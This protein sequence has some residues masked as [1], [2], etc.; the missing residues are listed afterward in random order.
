MSAPQQTLP[1][2]LPQK[3]VEDIVYGIDCTAQLTGAQTP[4]AVSVTLTKNGVPVTLVDPPIVVGNV[5]MQRVRTMVLAVGCLYQM[6]ALFT[7]ST[8]TN[9]LALDLGI[10]CPS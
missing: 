4:T 1:A 8:T 7:P 2:A 6:E 3:R 9:I 5:I 10:T